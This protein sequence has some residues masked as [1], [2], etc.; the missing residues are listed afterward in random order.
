MN[1]LI[2]DVDSVGDDILAM[3]YAALNRNV[4]LLGITTVIGAAGS[5]KQA[6]NVA[7]ET[8]ELTGKNI[9]VFEGESR[10]YLEKDINNGD[11]V[12]FF[13]EFRWK[14]GDRLKDF[15][16]I[17][18][19]TNLKKQNEHAVDFIIRSIEENR[20][21]ISL[22]FTGPLTNL[23]RVVEKRPDV[24]KY[25]KKTYI[26][27]GAFKYPGNISPV[28]EYNIQADPEAAKIVFNSDLE[29]TLVPLDVCENNEF[30]SSMMTRDHISDLR[31][32][33]KDSRV[34]NYIENK[35]PIYI[36]MWRTYFDLAGFPMDDVIT[37]AL[38]CGFSDVEYYP[39]VS[40]DV[41]LEGKYSRGQTIAFF[42]NQVNKYSNRNRK[43]V[44][45][46]KSISGKSF[47]KEFVDVVSERRDCI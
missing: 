5:I 25:I 29:I 33:N 32:L 41:E 46:V 2:L 8:I 21:E 9:K 36:D 42:W 27:G 4:E 24:V 39:P 12:N 11:P 40:V 7:L 6:T 22:I 45:I 10:P 23:A 31:Y 30:A 14:F 37:V 26:L 47:M 1:K 16:T 38:A 35:F 18:E 15:N 13:E 3:L 44:S 20:N 28:T 17:V 34:V 19:E 43:N